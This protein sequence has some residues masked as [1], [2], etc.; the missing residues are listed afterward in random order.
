M[1]NLVLLDPEF[2]LVNVDYKYSSL[3]KENKSFYPYYNLYWQDAVKIFNI[4]LPSTIVT[5]A[6]GFSICQDCGAKYV[7]KQFLCER[8]VF[9]YNVEGNWSN[10]TYYGNL[11]IGDVHRE[12]GGYAYKVI[13]SYERE[14]YSTNVKWDLQKEFNFQVSFFNFLNSIAYLPK[15]SNSCLEEFADF[16][17]HSKYDLIDMNIVRA[18]IETLERQNIQLVNV[19]KEIAQRMSQAGN[20]LNLGNLI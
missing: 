7:G 19:I 14:C 1:N 16:I 2:V 17:P 3:N 15:E 20:A 12:K 9:L 6:D 13:K 5:L 10:P 8:K 11:F 4:S 18:R